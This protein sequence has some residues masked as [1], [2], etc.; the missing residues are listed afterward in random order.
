[1]TRQ[2][3]VVLRVVLRVKAQDSEEAEHKALTLFE[4]L[5]ADVSVVDAVLADDEIIGRRIRWVSAPWCRRSLARKVEEYCRRHGLE[6]MLTETRKWMWSEFDLVV[7]G[8]W[9]K[10]LHL[11]RAINF[12]ICRGV[13]EG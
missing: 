1:M 6:Y 3:D 4:G 13:L 7:A 10:V 11:E 2:Y 8:P 12:P 5:G 9:R